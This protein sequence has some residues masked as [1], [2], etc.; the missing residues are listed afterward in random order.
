[1]SSGVGPRAVSDPWAE[2]IAAL[3]PI[4]SSSWTTPF[5][6]LLPV[7]GMSVS[8]LGDVL[9]SETLFASDA[10]AARVDEAQFDLSEGPCWDAIATRLPVFESDLGGKGPGRWPVLTDALA[11]D[12]VQGLFVFPLI[13]G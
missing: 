9:E 1:M 10:V 2:A 11:G 13:L 3:T 6:E 8:T 12:G 5:L 4:P 7:S